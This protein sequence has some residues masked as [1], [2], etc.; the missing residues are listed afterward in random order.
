M[1]TR[2]LFIISSLLL[3]SACN[4]NPEPTTITGQVRTFGTET[5]INH[6]PVVVEIVERRASGT[7]GAGD[8]YTVITS[9]VTDAQGRYTL[10][11]DLYKNHQYILNVSKESIQGYHYVKADYRL[12]D[13]ER[14]RI[15]HRGGTHTQNFYMWAFGWVEFQFNNTSNATRFSYNVGSGGFEVFYS[16]TGTIERTWNFVGGAEHP[17]YMGR[18]N[19]TNETLW[20]EYFFALPFDTVKHVVNY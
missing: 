4:K 11:G 16:P 13:L 1:K 2:I 19:G 7:W 17:I 3:L 6:P 8:I 9:T 5:A 18:I 20:T 14:N 12:R 10:N 15:T